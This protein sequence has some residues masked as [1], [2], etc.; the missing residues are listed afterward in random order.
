MLL[1]Q[2]DF[3][4]RLGGIV[5]V[6]ANVRKVKVIKWKKFEFALT[7][8]FFPHTRVATKHRLFEL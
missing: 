6:R 8:H 2:R 5:A 7:A 3:L 1:T 4:R